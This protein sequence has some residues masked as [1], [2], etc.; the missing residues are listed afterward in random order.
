VKTSTREILEAIAFLPAIAVLSIVLLALGYGVIVAGGWI[1]HAWF[2]LLAATGLPRPAA[3]AIA[4]LLAAV[5]VTG[6]FHYLERG[7]SRRRR[8]GLKA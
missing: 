8:M 3:L 5:T 1:L 7:R 6:G 2:W 4:V